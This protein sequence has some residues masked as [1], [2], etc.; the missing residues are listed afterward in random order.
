MVEPPTTIP[1]RAGG[2]PGNNLAK[3]RGH[4]PVLDTLWREL[5]I[6][7]RLLMTNCFHF[8]VSY[9][10]TLIPRLMLDSVPYNQ[11]IKALV[12]CF[13]YALLTAYQFEIANQC[14]SPKEDQVNKPHRPIPAGLLTIAD[15]RKRWILSWLFIPVILHVWINTEAALWGCLAQGIIAF[16]YLWPAF[17]NP[18]C[19][20]I[21]AGIMIVPLKRGLNAL[22]YT[23]IAPEA[24]LSIWL[25]V[26][27]ALWFGTTCHIQ[28]FRDVKGDRV[29]NKRTLPVVLSPRGMRVV[30]VLTGVYVVSLSVLACWLVTQRV[31]SSDELVLWTAYLHLFACINLAFRLVWSEK[32]AHSTYQYAYYLAF[33]TFEVGLVLVYYWVN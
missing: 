24:N 2:T 9:Y 12:S 15:A 14:T 1:A 5:D 30:R 7:Y 18:L 13:P 8:V 28:E 26:A 32:L 31:S 6:T 20:N 16:F 11:T 29:S 4:A 33:W 3:R 17:N 25:D 10:I 19:R 27:S 22:Y 21:F 23:T